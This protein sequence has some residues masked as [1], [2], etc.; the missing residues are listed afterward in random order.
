M[1]RDIGSVPRVDDE[2][3]A[4]WRGS[5]IGVD[6]NKKFCLVIHSLLAKPS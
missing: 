5:M 1:N 3:E 6:S 4:M 2:E